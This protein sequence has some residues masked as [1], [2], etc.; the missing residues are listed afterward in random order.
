MKII[1][2]WLDQGAVVGAVYPSFLLVASAVALII[3]ATHLVSLKV[4]RYKSF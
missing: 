4:L 1:Q 2:D 3:T